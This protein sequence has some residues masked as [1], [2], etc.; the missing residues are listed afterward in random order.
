MQIY[1]DFL[2]IKRQWQKKK[3][4][5]VKQNVYTLCLKLTNILPRPTKQGFRNNWV[6][7]CIDK[8]HRDR[9]IF[10]VH[11]ATTLHV[12]VV[13]RIKTSYSSAQQINKKR[14]SLT[15]FSFH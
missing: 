12:E 4:V 2:K 7:L 1:R 10:Q 13:N 3:N 9:N 11:R 14:N 6:I 5:L 8:N 15:I